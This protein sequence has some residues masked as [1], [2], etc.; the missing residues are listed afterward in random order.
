MNREANGGGDASP[1]PPRDDVSARH[2]P[3]AFAGEQARL[4]KIWT[5]LG[6]TSDVAG[7]NDWFRASLGGRSILVQRFEAGLRAFE[8]RCAHRGYPLRTETR[9]N[10]AL[11][12]GFHHWRYN[13][14][15]LALGIPECPAMFGKTP[16][17]LDAR[18]EP[19]EIKTC[20]GMIFGRFKGGDEIP[21][22]EWLGPGYAILSHISDGLAGSLVRPVSI[23]E[24]VVQANWRYMMDISL[25]DYHIV[26]VHPST[27]GQEGYIPAGNI[28]YARFGAHSAY[29]SGGEA[30]ELAR[31]ARDCEAGTFMPARYRILQIFPTLIVSMVR[32]LRFNGDSYWF[33][34]LQHLIPEAHDRTR[35][36]SRFFPLR[37]PET[38]S[39]PR[40]LI[41]KAFWPGTSLGFRFYA[42][43]VHMEDNAVCETL[44]ASARPDD[45]PP[46]LARQEERIGWFSESYRRVMAG[47]TPAATPDQAAP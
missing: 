4:G 16:R 8:N 19:V 44:Q 45:P 47:E 9:G 33:L 18:L 5:F 27:F 32:A 30:D 12:C 1:P 35:S 21:L 38:D 22:K 39:L 40:R 41:R 2:D 36:V 15:G 17:E 46:R 26:A 31:F 37:Q 25:D 7:L 24:Q 23:F 34:V 3:R 29:F 20:G 42:R 14:D 13:A 6:L 11:V 10:G 28:H 43:R